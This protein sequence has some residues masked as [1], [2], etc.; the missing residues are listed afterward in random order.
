MCAVS[1]TNTTSTNLWPGFFLRPLFEFSA[2]QKKLKCIFIQQHLLWD[3]TNRSVGVSVCFLDIRVTWKSSSVYE[4][5]SC[6]RP[7]LTT[8]PF[9][10]AWQTLT[11]PTRWR[12][13]SSSTSSWNCRTSCESRALKQ[14][15][16]EFWPLGHSKKSRRCKGVRF[17]FCVVRTNKTASVSGV[18]SSSVSESLWKVSQLTICQ[19]DFCHD[20][21]KW[22]WTRKKDI[23]REYHIFSFSHYIGF[24][25]HLE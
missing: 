20:V 12:N 4:K 22:C 1:Y 6:R 7:F 15:N 13:N 14:V 5:P 16:C 18:C 2:K 21:W 9:S 11:S 8:K 17:F 3:W 10:R 23:S 24:I 25:G 19:K